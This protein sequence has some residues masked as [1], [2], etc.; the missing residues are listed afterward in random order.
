MDQGWI[1]LPD[2]RLADLTIRKG[3]VVSVYWGYNVVG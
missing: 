1:L 3:G 2:D